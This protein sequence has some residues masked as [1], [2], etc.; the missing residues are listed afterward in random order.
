MD[1]E[2]GK[3]ELKHG[4][5]GRAM[6][7]LID[8][9]FRPA[10]ANVFLEQG[11]D[12]ALLP[13]AVGRMVMTTDS[14]VVS[15]MFFPGGDIG[16]LAVNGTI[17]DIAMAGAVPLYLSAGFII[18]EGF[19]LAD[20]KKIAD[21]MGKASKEAGVPI[22]TGDT[23]VVEKGKGDGVFINT[24]AVGFVPDRVDM[25]GNKARAGDA[26]IISGTI[27]DHGIAVLSKKEGMEFDCDVVSDTVALHNLV[28][29][30]VASAGPK[31]RCLR[32]P[33]RGGVSATLNEIAKQ[34]KVGI[35]IKEQNIPVKNEVQAAANMLGF[36]VLNLANEGKLI[37]ICEGSIAEQ[38]LRVM[39][40]NPLGKNAT[41]IG[42]V[43]RDSDCLVQ[44]ETKAGGLRLVHWL[45][46]EELPRIC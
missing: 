30:M 16:S 39:R 24:A 34:S 10:F 43:V 3:I 1:L 36:D 26:V 46:G 29:A 28:R 27:G 11:N 21:S 40:Q 8:E 25:S 14:H 45:E 22:V 9:I 18:E 33:T 5:G 13:K 19:P 17:N 32:D 44:M 15:P 35:V 12:Q 38:L 20:L 23:K 7:E 4:A 6:I 2:K 31:I 41:I 42:K 37:A